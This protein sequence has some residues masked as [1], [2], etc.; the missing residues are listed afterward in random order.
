MTQN[1]KRNVGATGATARQSAGLENWYLTVANASRGA[2]GAA[3]AST[4]GT[5]DNNVAVTDGTQRAL[6]EAL[7]EGV[8][9]NVWNSGGDPTIIMSGPFN[10]V[11]I[12]AFAGNSTRFDKGEDKR[13]TA[14]IDIY[15]SDFGDHRIVPNRFSRDRTVHVITPRLFSVDYLRSF[16]QH[17][18]AKTGDSE[19]RQLLAEWTLRSSNE[20][21][22][23]VVADLNTS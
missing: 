10:K 5:P 17:P 7:F 18:L 9:R 14:A 8:I 16:R 20:A 2:T 19:R 12:S 1:T 13:L 15:V 3:C 23:G 4:A 22:S 11:A 21:G 6:T